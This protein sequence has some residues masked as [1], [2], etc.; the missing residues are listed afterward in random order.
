MTAL[1][2]PLGG[3]R[4]HYNWRG[5]DIAYVQRGNG[6]AMLLVHSIHACA[7]SMEWREVVPTLSA[8]YTTY[9]I[10]LLGFGASAHPALHYSADLYVDLVRDFLRDVVRSAAV[11]VGSSLG[12]TYCVAVA[13]ANP[14]LAAAVCA[15]GPAGVSRLTK[16]GGT[17]GSIVQGL[18]RTEFPGA[19]L[20]AA[21]VSKASI[22]FFLKDIYHD[23]RRMMTDDVVNLYWQSA[24]QHNARF[25]PSAFVGMRL[26]LDIRDALVRMPRPFLLAW[27]EYAAQTPFREAATVHALRPNEPFAVLD[28]GDLPHEEAP[29][30]FL[31]ALTE[32]LHSVSRPD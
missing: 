6:P 19:A 2:N 9:S 8:H 28:A 1:P 26:N 27:G 16:A 32:F 20:F 21:L 15:I 4:R 30:A 14:E 7:W 13:A 17:A 22:R 23:N 24:R 3:E 10:D 11:L 25:A 31:G 5:H 12:G 18:F 29:A